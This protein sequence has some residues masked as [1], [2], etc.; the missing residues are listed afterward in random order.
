[1]RRNPFQQTAFLLSCAS[2]EQLPADEQPE[3]AFAGRS[4]AG[5]S[6]ALNAL[7]GQKQL[8]RVSKTPGRTQ[9]INLFGVPGLGRLADLPGY[10]YAE[11]PR[12]VSRSWGALIGG[13]VETRANLRGLVVI[14]DIRHPLTDYDVQMLS[15]AGTRALHCHVLLTKA[16]KLGFGAAKNQLLKVKRELAERPV[17]V[18]LFS[19]TSAQGVDEARSAIERLLRQA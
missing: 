10:G 11:V 8:A 5:K 17:S 14:M 4:N 13:Y 3:I 18:Q 6:S 2:L 12:E 1:M 7:C 19:A 15:W 9:L 16:D